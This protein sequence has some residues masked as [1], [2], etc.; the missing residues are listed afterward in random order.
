MA[1]LSKACGAAGD[2]TS[3]CLCLPC[4]EFMDLPLWLLSR[5]ALIL[6]TVAQWNRLINK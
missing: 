3:M 4:A 2:R 6:L 1:A 5:L